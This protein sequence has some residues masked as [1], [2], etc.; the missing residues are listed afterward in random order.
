MR[1]RKPIRAAARAQPGISDEEAMVAKL[2]VLSGLI[3]QQI[4]SAKAK[5][6]KL[7]I[8]QTEVDAAFADVTRTSPTMRSSR[9]CSNAA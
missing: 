9:S 3:D 7:E 1:S 8:P 4:L 2:N 6:Q 5:A